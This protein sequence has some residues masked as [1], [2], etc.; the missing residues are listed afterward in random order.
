MM[1]TSHVSRSRSI[2]LLRESAMRTKTVDRSERVRT[3]NVSTLVPSR[4]AREQTAQCKTTWPFAGVP[5]EPLE[6]HSA[7]VADS[8]ERKSVLPVVPT[9]TVRLASTSLDNSVHFITFFQMKNFFDQVGP[10]DRPICRCKNT[11]I[12][13]PLQGC[14][15]E[16]DTDNECGQSQKCDRITYRCETACGQ[17]VCGENANCQAINHRAQ[18]SCPPDFLGDAR[19]RCYTE[20]TRHDECSDNQACVKFTCKDP[21][22]EPDPNVCGSGANCEVKNHKPICTCPYFPIPCGSGARCQPGNDRFDPRP[23]CT[24]PTGFRGD[25]LVSCTRG[26]YLICCQCNFYSKKEGFMVN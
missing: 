16:C 23:V 3:T 14:R 12:G 8:L 7:T 20:C 21:C 18:C 15:H 26:E 10:D 22:R 6:I 19:T 2:I 25:P 11:Y 1:N 9:L 13:N 17:G 5:G 24:C 4:V